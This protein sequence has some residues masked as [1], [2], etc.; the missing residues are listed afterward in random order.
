MLRTSSLWSQFN[1]VWSE[2]SESKELVIF[3]VKLV[4]MLNNFCQKMNEILC[5]EQFCF[6]YLVLTEIRANKPYCVITFLF[7]NANFL[8]ETKTFKIFNDEFSHAVLH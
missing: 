5:F 2:R 1:T 3:D 7:L 8:L 6:S 4:K